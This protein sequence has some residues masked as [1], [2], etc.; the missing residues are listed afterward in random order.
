LLQLAPHFWKPGAQASLQLPFAHTVGAVQATPHAPQLVLSV[1]RLT[2]APLQAVNPGWHK[3]PFAPLPAVLPGV[4]PGGES[5]LPV[6]ALTSALSS[7]ESAASRPPQDRNQAPTFQELCI[8]AA[9]PER[10]A[11]TSRSKH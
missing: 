5:M 9:R 4:P 11:P 6:H 8:W 3:S 2:H 10:K 7:N 1:C